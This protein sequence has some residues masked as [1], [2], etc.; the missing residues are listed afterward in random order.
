M[1]TYQKFI[2]LIVVACLASILIF[3]KV[4]KAK[5]VTK[6]EDI[7]VTQKKAET[8]F[9]E[10]TNYTFE[11]PNIIVNP[12]GISP[13]TALIIFETK[14]LTTPTVTIKG[15][16][17]NTTFT[18]TFT[19]GKKHILPIYG[20]YANQDNEV[21]LEINGKS[22]TLHIKTDELPKDF[23]MPT[24]VE[25]NKEALEND[26]YFFTPSSSGYTCA[27]D[28]NGDVRWYLKGNFVW[29]IKRLE[30]GNLLLSSNRL[31][32]PPYYTSGLVEMDLTGKIYFEYSIP[33]GYHHDAYE[34]PN[35]NLL[36]ASDDFESGNGT[37]EDYLVEIDRKTGEIVKTID[38]KNILP[39]EE[40]KSANW[41]EYDWFHNNSVWYDEKTN[42]ITLSG[43]HQDIVVNINYDTEEIN[44][45]LG[46]PEGWDEKYQKYF[47]QKVG[48][49]E[50]DWQ[51]AQHAA[52]ILPNGNVFLFDNGNN[53]SKNKDNYVSAE[54]NFS[55]GVIY[56]INNTNKTIEQ[57]W[58]YGKSLGSSFYSPYISDV[59]YLNDGHYLIHSGGISTTDG[60]P[61]NVP[62]SFS[63]NAKLKSI[64]V[65]VQDDEE[66]FKLELPS[67][68]YRSEKMSLYANN[69]Y[70]PGP[71]VRLGNL[72]ETKANGKN[73]L[74]LFSKSIDK[75]YK[76]H[77]IKITKESDRLVF[78]GTFK[79]SDKV[80][81]ILDNLV[82]KKT[83]QLIISKKPYT[84]MCIDVFNEQEK[85]DGISVTKYINDEGMSGKYYIYVRING[86][87]YDVDKYVI[88]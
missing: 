82:D 31:V 1:K 5:P 36:V 11:D 24:N 52:M 17:E 25:A 44:W 61:N 20:L 35:G 46:D 2:L 77:N 23:V 12:Y 57:V 80:E 14:D 79:K 64:T 53:R 48:N 32:N 85:K 58:E 37:V 13:L 6:T 28:V 54:N 7:L 18:H 22:Q 51:Y 40:G 3:Y 84:A 26:L 34:M 29:D 45:I 50:F 70:K 74:I 65:E 56:K 4:D 81:V 59:D 47:F 43:R 66:I 19:P 63:D 21:I 87:T 88:Y 42:S 60:K 68:Y 67:N 83:Y 38:L 39:T 73:K 76:E 33:G 72:G 69:V 55:R 27:F 71:G 49:G 41:T 15:K 75:N 86:K 30:N 16:D 62:A 8:K 10:N 9:L 78:T